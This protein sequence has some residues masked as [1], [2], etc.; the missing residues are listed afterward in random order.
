VYCT[1]TILDRNN[2]E[3]Q[4]ITVQSLARV[5]AENNSSPNTG[6]KVKRASPNKDADRSMSGKKGRESVSRPMDKEEPK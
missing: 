6:E 1:D 5:G 3:T 4:D 2:Q